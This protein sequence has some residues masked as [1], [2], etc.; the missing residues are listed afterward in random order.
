[1]SDQRLEEETTCLRHPPTP[2]SWTPDSHPDIPMIPVKPF[3]DAVITDERAIK[4]RHCSQ[5]R[6]DW[7]RS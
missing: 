2:T 7:K 3:N 6:D 4:D 1:M 5:E